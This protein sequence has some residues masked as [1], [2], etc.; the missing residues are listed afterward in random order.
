MEPWEGK[1]RGGVLGYKI[2]VWTLSTLGISF[3]YF[4]L[5]F[6][7]VYFVF[8]SGKAFGSVYRYFREHQ[9]FGILKSLISICR[10]Y[11]VFGQILVDKLALLAGF[12]QKF[13]FDFEGE[14][15]LRQMNQGG[16]LISG[17]VGNWEIA[18]QLL[19]RLEKK[20]NILMYDAEHQ[21]IKGYLADVLKRNVGF[22]IIR[23]D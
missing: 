19:V 4:L 10:N 3:A 2:F 7:V 11:Y 13:T 9:N 15:Y 23:D 6:V 17:H 20:I 14:E 16:L 12:Q 22:I 1:T 8:T 18:G 21:K 5:R